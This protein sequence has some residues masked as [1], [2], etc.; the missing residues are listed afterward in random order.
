[1]EAVMASMGAT[2]KPDSGHRV[3]FSRSDRPPTFRFPILRY[4]SVLAI[5][6]HTSVKCILE[7]TTDIIGLQEKNSLGSGTIRVTSRL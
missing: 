3:P 4:A 6:L 7:Q 2:K 5:L 1:M